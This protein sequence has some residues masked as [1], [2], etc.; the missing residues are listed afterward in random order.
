MVHFRV[1]DEE[2]ASSYEGSCAYVE[3]VAA[4]S[5]KG[6]FLQLFNFTPKEF[7]NEKLHRASSLV[8]TSFISFRIGISG[9]LL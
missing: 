8:W 7:G 5:R 3:Q 4:N 1:V 9:G 2:R 6:V